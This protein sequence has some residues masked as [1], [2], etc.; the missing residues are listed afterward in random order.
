MVAVGTMKHDF[1]GYNTYRELK[2]R[3]ETSSLSLLSSLP[4]RSLSLKTVPIKKRRRKT[5]YGDRHWYHQ[6][7]NLLVIN[8]EEEETSDD[9]D[10]DVWEA[11]KYTRNVASTSNNKKCRRLI[12]S[13]NEEDYETESDCSHFACETLKK[14][15]NRKNPIGNTRATSHYNSSSMQQEFQNSVAK[16][17]SATDETPKGTRSGHQPQSLAMMVGKRIQVQ[18]DM[19]D[20]TTEWYSGIVQSCSGDGSESVLLYDDGDSILLDNNDPPEWRP[21]PTA[22]YR[23]KTTD[24]LPMS[25]LLSLRKFHQELSP[26]THA[27]VKQNGRYSYSSE[28]LAVSSHKS[29]VL[30]KKNKIGQQ[31]QQQ[32]QQQCSQLVSSLSFAQTK[33]KSKNVIIDLTTP[34]LSTMSNNNSNSLGIVKCNQKV[35]T[36]KKRKKKPEKQTCQKLQRNPVMQNKSI[37]EQ[38]QRINQ[39][40][41]QKPPLSPVSSLSLQQTNT[42]STA[43][44]VIDLTS[45]IFSERKKKGSEK[46]HCQQLQQK[47]TT[48]DLATDEKYEKKLCLKC[49]RNTE[50]AVATSQDDGINFLLP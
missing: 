40:L 32:Q 36:N 23:N 31:Q 6:D 10:D 38:K 4:P 12:L 50:K 47:S 48:K 8:K 9:D 2:D 39:Q 11:R 42:I 7:T 28:N 34:P 1:W 14:E 5:V 30:E 18:W 24:L 16:K 33:P 44:T 22:P 27:G 46:Q 19:S 35:L 45:P 41:Q 21:M 25:P 29:N 26:P 3:C 17:Q 49:E 15:L 37:H 13:D 43:T 20:G